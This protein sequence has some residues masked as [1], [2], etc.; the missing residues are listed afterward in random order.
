VLDETDWS[1][2]ASRKAKS[3][4]ERK[5][6]GPLGGRFQF[7]KRDSPDVFWTI[8][9]IEARSAASRPF[10]FVPPPFQPYSFRSR[11]EDIGMNARI[12]E[13]R[14]FLSALF[15][16]EGKVGITRSM[17]RQLVRH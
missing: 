2:V 12:A 5:C 11:P 8:P 3:G 13:L 9:A 1:P 15:E 6:N 14:F 10:P 7:A 17:M 16:R 4:E